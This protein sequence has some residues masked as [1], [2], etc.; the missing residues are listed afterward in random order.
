MIFFATAIAITRMQWTGTEEM[1]RHVLESVE[2]SPRHH[3]VDG[4]LED[5]NLIFLAGISRIA[6]PPL[7]GPEST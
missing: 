5:E 1:M 4:G 3:I 7:V 6:L 2:E